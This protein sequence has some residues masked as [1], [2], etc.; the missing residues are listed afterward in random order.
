[1]GFGAQ[2]VLRLTRRL[3]GK[4][5]QQLADY[6]YLSIG[7]KTRRRMGRSGKKRGQK[8]SRVVRSS[9]QGKEEFP[10]VTSNVKQHTEMSNIANAVGAKPILS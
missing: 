6:Q 10:R 3:C 4:G 2:D 1:M 9:I 5:R 7:K 8:T